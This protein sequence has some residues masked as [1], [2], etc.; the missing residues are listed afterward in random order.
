MQERLILGGNQ[1]QRASVDP[2]DD[3]RAI[4]RERPVDVR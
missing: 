2:G 4:I 1:V 3:Q